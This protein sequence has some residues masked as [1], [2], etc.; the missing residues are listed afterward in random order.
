MDAPKADLG[1]LLTRRVMVKACHVGRTTQH[2]GGIIE[3]LDDRHV[4]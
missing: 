3:A 4:H 2:L 1:K